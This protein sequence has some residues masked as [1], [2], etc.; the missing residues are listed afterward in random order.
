ME[1]LLV[2]LLD[3][4]A[5][6]KIDTDMIQKDLD[7]RNQVPHGDA[8]QRRYIDQVEIL[9]GVFEGMSTELRSVCKLKI[10]IKNL[11]IIQILQM[12]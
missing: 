7:R 3:V 9:S 12:L 6:V 11:K 10:L 2:A 8:T 4:R 5:R 1:N